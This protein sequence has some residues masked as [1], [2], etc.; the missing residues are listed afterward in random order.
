MMKIST[1]KPCPI[2]ILALILAGLISLPAHAEVIPGRW[3]KVSDLDLG[4]PI[5]VEL[6][7]GD[8]VEGDFEGLSGSEVELETN[9]ARAFIPKADIETI[10]TRPRG[11]RGN[12]AAIGAAIGLGL[13]LGATGL[14]ALRGNGGGDGLSVPFA[15]LLVTG[16]TGGLGAAM[17]A[18]VDSGTKSDPI[19]LYE[20]PSASQ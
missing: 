2:Q 4:T 14:A 18:A 13:G 8:R 17:G 20:V 19:V 7:S 15:L 11:G 16:I 12:G 6:K 10:T 5:T 9:S 1:I 3:E